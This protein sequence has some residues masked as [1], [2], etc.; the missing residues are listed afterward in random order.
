MAPL[1]LTPFEEYFFE[2]DDPKSP[3]TFYFRFKFAGKL[4]LQ[5]VRRALDRVAAL[6]PL[7]TSKIVVGKRRRL[8]WEEAGCGIPM[9]PLNLGSDSLNSDT[10]FSVMPQLDITKGPSLAV[11]FA[12]DP[13]GAFFVLVFCVHH[14]A[15]DGGGF[16]QLFSDW[17]VAY[18]CYAGNPSPDV[19]L[20]CLETYVR[21]D[22][23]QRCRPNLSLGEQW[24]LLP[25]QWKSV[26]AAFQV[27]NRTTITLTNLIPST[28]NQKTITNGGQGK[29]FRVITRTL[30]IQ[31]T[32]DL[33]DTARRLET[34]SNN[35]LARDM[36]VSI[37][38]WQSMN[39][40][41]PNGSHFRV[42]IPINE[43]TGQNSNMSA[44]NH[45]TLINLD[46]SVNELD[47][48]DELAVSIRQEMNVIKRWRLSL[49]FWRCLAIFGKLPRALTRRLDVD[50][51]SATTLLSNMG[52]LSEKIDV[53]ARQSPW[54]ERMPTIESLEIVPTIHKGMAASFALSYFRQR[55]S[56][57][58]QF[59]EEL[60]NVESATRLI[61]IFEAS[62][63]RTAAAAHLSD[64]T[65]T[66]RLDLQIDPG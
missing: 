26:R 13:D 58:M 49:N 44:C 20:Q 38:K 35:L 12:A 31:P 3:S 2:H 54:P 24:K 45:C 53:A 41:Q 42:M 62:I 46:R 40:F 27:L 60:I 30:R 5:V 51:I 33:S 9:L 66:S 64:P 17:L 18:S 15:F 1:R 10:E 63:L 50:S 52:N 19:D 39:Q 65:E 43:R 34:T 36:F 21:G 59:K 29:G 8:R 4:D 11:G 22:L 56:I 61:T 55:L 47:D 7:A 6:H 16:F 48:A 23:R 28:E 57:T 32:K 14:C 25:G 37:A